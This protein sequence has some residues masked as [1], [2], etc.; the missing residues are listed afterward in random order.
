MPT[1]WEHCRGVLRC[2][3]E[4]WLSFV[5]RAEHIRSS[6][7]ICCSPEMK[8]MMFCFASTRFFFCHLHV[9]KSV[10]V[11]TVWKGEGVLIKQSTH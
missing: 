8:R 11:D 2:I 3:T 6:S 7:V 1:D 10:A 5:I 4:A 9:P